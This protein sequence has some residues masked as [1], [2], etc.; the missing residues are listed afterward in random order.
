MPKKPDSAKKR[1][2]RR[3]FALSAIVIFSVLALATIVVYIVFMGAP[4]K[5]LATTFQECKDAGG[6]I[7][8]SYPEQ[9]YIRGKSFINTAQTPQDGTNNSARYI[10]LSEHAAIKK[11][12]EANIP[13]RVV[14]RDGESL[15][16]T[17]DLV[18]GRLNFFV[19]DG[20]VYKIDV[21]S[22]D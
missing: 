22:I 10:G 4:Q 16:V 13:N 8:E 14:E 18:E 11:T 5:Q 21:E 15:P 7:A 1:A 17:M 19:R 3:A 9:C 6:R 12:D 20:L 2:A